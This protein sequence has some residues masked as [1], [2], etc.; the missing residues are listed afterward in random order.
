MIARTDGVPLLVEEVLADRAAGALPIQVV[1]AK[2]EWVEI[3]DWVTE[4]C[5]GDEKRKLFRDNA[6]A[7]Y[8]L[9]K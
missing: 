2:P 5:S 9:D 6:I 3:V 8:R 7:F 1:S 4:G